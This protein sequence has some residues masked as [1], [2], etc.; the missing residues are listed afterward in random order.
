MDISVTKSNISNAISSLSYIKSNINNKNVTKRFK[1]IYKKLDTVLDDLY[2]EAANFSDNDYK[3]ELVECY[4]P[5]S[6]YK[7]STGSFTISIN[8]EEF[9]FEDVPYSPYKERVYMEDIKE[10]F[11]DI[12]EEELVDNDYQCIADLCT[13]YMD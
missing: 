9:Y 11:K 6:P 5:K 8:E 13:S 3:W 1:D 12:N 2:D 4:F 10:L 7:E